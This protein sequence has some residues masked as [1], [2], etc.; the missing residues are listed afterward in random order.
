MTQPAQSSFESS[1]TRKCLLALTSALALSGAGCAGLASPTSESVRNSKEGAACPAPEALIDDGEDGQN[2]SAV[3]DGRGGYWYTFVDTA[4]STVWPTAGAQG[5]TFEMSP[6]GAQGTAYA[7][8]FKGQ[9]GTGTVVFVGAGVNF[10]D[11][12]GQYDASKYGGIS[13]WAKKGPGSTNKVRLKIPDAYTDPDGGHCSECFNDLGA[14]FTLT[15]EWQLFTF[16]FKSLRQL[17][18]WGRPRRFK[19]DSSTIYSI[20]FQVNDPGQPYDVFIDEIRFTG[21]GG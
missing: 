9:I 16:P 17:P 15:E 19:V 3:V 1:L 14:D 21:C 2:Q 10:V 8:R 20:Q 13:F 6:G 11:P 4:G 12:K 7:A 5:G 18:G